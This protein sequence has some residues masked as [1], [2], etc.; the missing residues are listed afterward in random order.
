M[1]WQEVK[2]MDQKVLFLA[3]WL[4]KMASFTE[5]CERYC[6]SRKTGYKWIK[7]YEDI[8]YDGL[9]DRSR[10]PKNSPQQTPYPVRKAILELRTRGRIT[11]G[12]K[13]IQILLKQRFPHEHIPS[14]TTIYNILR[15][16]GLVK[17]RRRR[18]RVSPFEHP[19]SPTSE[20]ND[21]WSADFKGQFKMANGQWCYPL[22]I[23]DHQSR[24]LLCC[25]G[26]EGTRFN[27]TQKAF[28]QLFKKYGLPKRIRTDNG[29]PFATI[30]VA[31]L[32]RLAVWWIT[33]GILP[34]RIQPGQPQQN[35]RHERMHRTLKQAATK[36]PEA[37][38]EKQQEV[39][40]EFCHNY[41]VERPHEALGQKPPAQFYLPSPRQY[42]DSTQDLKY[43][44]YCEVRTVQSA[45]V[46]YFLG[47][48][49][50]VS[51]LLKGHC[52]GLCET[53]EGIW[54]IYF[55][56][57]RLGYFEIKNGKDDET[58]YLTLKV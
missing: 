2:P 54:D 23:M 31:G 4:R 47:R 7:R 49:I 13:K 17:K 51:H 16:E 50:Y 42:P 46:V 6:I 32:S 10:R 5:L 20:A 37:S 35:G 53:A 9:Y 22:T 26:L 30:A 38:L 40:D 1:P 27:E 55:G 43:P 3:D 29:V 12:P 34:E 41:N 14:E 25:Q 24:Y 56:P 44:D 57:I 39:F 33:L 19:F 48:Q 28:Q 8:G 15:S 11:F 45:G 52:V 58:T 36:P 18:Q 21:L